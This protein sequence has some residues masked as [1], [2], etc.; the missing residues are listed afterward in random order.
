MSLIV[1]L[2]LNHSIIVGADRMASCRSKTDPDCFSDRF[3]DVRKLYLYSDNVV[4]GFVGKSMISWFHHDDD[5]EITSIPVQTWFDKFKRANPGLPVLSVPTALLNFA[6]EHDSETTGESA[7]FIA[8]MDQ[9]GNK[10]FSSVNINDKKIT[11]SSNIGRKTLGVSDVADAI[12]DMCFL[13]HFKRINYHEGVQLVKFCIE[14]TEATARFSSDLGVGGGCDIYVIKDN[15]ECGWAENHD[16]MLKKDE[17]T[18]TKKK[19]KGKS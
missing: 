9:Y 6:I 13:D 2:M 8:G 3:Y 18:V 19:G 12:L 10:M 1:A 4:V 5:P 15:G 14:T 11:L 16:I 17:K 7:F